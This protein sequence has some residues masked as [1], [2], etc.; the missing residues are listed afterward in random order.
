VILCENYFQPAQWLRQLILKELDPEEAKRVSSRV[1][2]IE[3]MV[4]RS[5]IEASEAEKAEDPLCLRAQNMWKLPADK[6]GFIGE[7]PAIE[8]LDARDISTLPGAE[9]FYL[10][11]HQCHV[12]L[13]GLSEGPHSVE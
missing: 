4:L 11:H 8:G 12:R 5:T 2:I 10:Q 9:A 3:T 7:I 6:A 13:H 1:G